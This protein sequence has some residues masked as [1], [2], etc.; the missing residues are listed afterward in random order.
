MASS[1]WS[2]KKPGNMNIRLC[3]HESRD[4]ELYYALGL[5]FGCDEM[6]VKVEL[7]IMCCRSRV[8]KLYKKERLH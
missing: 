7:L 3:G 2:Q 6:S 5:R 8:S 1:F 4:V